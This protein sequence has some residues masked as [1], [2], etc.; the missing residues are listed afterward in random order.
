M[1]SSRCLRTLVVKLRLEPG[2]LPPPSLLQCFSVLWGL[3]YKQQQQQQQQHK[4]R[5]SSRP[6]HP[7]TDLHTLTVM[8]MP[9]GTMLGLTTACATQRTQS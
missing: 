6:E 7:A 2:P 1:T 9:V 3:A 8:Y 4:A 5:V